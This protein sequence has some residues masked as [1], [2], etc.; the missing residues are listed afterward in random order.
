MLAKFYHLWEMLFYL[1]IIDPFDKIFNVLLDYMEKLQVVSVDWLY[2]SGKLSLFLGTY[3][4]WWSFVAANFFRLLCLMEKLHT[5]FFL[6]SFVFTFMIWPCGIAL[7]AYILFFNILQSFRKVI[8]FFTKPFSF[9]FRFHVTSI[10]IGK[11]CP[12]YWLP[13]I[14]NINLI[15]CILRTKT[16]S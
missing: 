9:H 10:G 14:T 1:N 5:F 8:I 7:L 11:Y 3:F 4:S 2:E 16:K 12:S 13:F 15:S 6:F